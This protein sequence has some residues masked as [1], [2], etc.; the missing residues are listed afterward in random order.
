MLREELA[1]TE[2]PQL[3]SIGEQQEDV[4]L[5]SPRTLD[6]A[7]DLEQRGHAGTIVRGAGRSGNAV[8]VTHEEERW[9]RRIDAR[10]TRDDVLDRE[11]VAFR[12]V[13]DDTV[14]ALALD[15][16]AERFQS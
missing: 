7:R 12:L 9:L 5:R 15:D 16:E 13:V 1:R 2:Q 11:R 4:S 14:Y 6:D 8:V 10:D 3:F